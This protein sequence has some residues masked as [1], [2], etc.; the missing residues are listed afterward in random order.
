[1]LWEFLK[2]KMQK[3]PNKRV[4]ENGA[5]MTFEELIVFAENFSERLKGIKCCAVLCESEMAAGMALLACFAAGITAVPLSRRYGELHCNK[6]LDLVSPD[7]VITDENGKLQIMRIK[8]AAYTEPQ[9]HPALIMC[10]SGTTGAPKGA[11]LTE[12]N[13]I[14]NV[15]DIADY[16]GISGEDK[17]LIARPLYHCAVLTGEFLTALIQGAEIRF[18]SGGFNPM[19]VLMLL[20]QYGITAFCGTP[21]LLSMMARLKKEDL[22]LKCICISGECMDRRTGLHISA[23][24]P[25]AEIYHIYGLTECS[26]RVAYLPPEMFKAYPDCVGLPLKSVSLKILDSNGNEVQKGETGV[27][28]VKGDNVMAGYYNNSEKTAEVLKNGWLC[29]GD[30]ALIN[31]AGLLKIK[32]R[33]DDLIIK[34]GMNIYPQEIESAL[35]LDTRVREVLACSERDD[36]L[37]MQ[38][39][40]TVAGEFSDPAEVREL[41][42][43]CLPAY[44]MPVRI[45]LVKEIPKNGSGKIIRR[46]KND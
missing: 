42:K 40:L 32:G 16:F 3:N 11:M 26:P 1:M 5:E 4:C 9:V 15:S 29:T 24:F 39:V 20:R 36:R 43:A 10:T 44:Q 12:K 2:S 37:G 6:I 30:T 41:C 25:T 14:A 38:I 7:A 23:A 27:L 19:A 13:I 8:N 21:T 45:A 46:W 31:K 35:K 33:S 22:T 34:A 17:L 18:Y 28:W